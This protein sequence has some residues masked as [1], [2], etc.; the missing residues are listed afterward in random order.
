MALWS[1]DYL[2]KKK[3]TP[4]I[5]EVYRPIP[6]SPSLRRRAPLREGKAS[7]NFAWI[8]GFLTWLVIITIVGG[9]WSWKAGCVTGTASTLLQSDVRQFL[10]RIISPQNSLITFN[11]STV[12]FGRAILTTWSASTYKQ[13]DWFSRY[14]VICCC[15][16]RG[17]G[18]RLLVYGN[19][20]S[21]W[22]I[23]GRGWKAGP[24]TRQ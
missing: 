5:S 7:G 17:L 8:L 21:S 10:R 20:W 16:K 22:I 4:K 23:Y 3:K 9:V 12:L 6:I 2:R 24:V 18:T 14:L 15:K 13:S 11:L 19:H 1:H